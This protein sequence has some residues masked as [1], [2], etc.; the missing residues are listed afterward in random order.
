MRNILLVIVCSLFCAGAFAQ[1][2]DSTWYRYPAV[3]PDGSTIAFCHGG[4]IYTVPVAGGV[5]RVLT[6]HEAHDF[7]PVWSP[8]GKTIAFASDR[9]GNYDVFTIPAS[10]GKPTRLTY[11]SS[12]DLPS[13][14]TP[15]GDKVLFSSRRTDDPGSS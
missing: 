14:F 2:T 10:G 12:N 1:D 5:A 15:E 6:L 7:M 4:D 11:Y 13:D 9:Y 8:D 3:S